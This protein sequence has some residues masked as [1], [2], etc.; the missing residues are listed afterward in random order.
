MGVTTGDDLHYKVGDSATSDTFRITLNSGRDW[1]L[2]TAS[3]V[4]ISTTGN[5]ITFSEQFTGYM[6]LAC[7]GANSADKQSVYD[8]YKDVIPLSGD[9][10]YSFA[11]DEATLTFSY[12]TAS[13]GD[14][15]EAD[16]ELLMFALPHHMD[17]LQS[18]SKV[19]AADF[20]TIKGKL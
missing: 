9:I 19:S 6:R 4:T 2:Y 1:M 15:E 14:M 10:D 3:P 7:L 16:G 5:E 20:A 18:P 12:K 17:I 11:G 8:E 13:L